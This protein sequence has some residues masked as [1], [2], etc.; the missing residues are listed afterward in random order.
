MGH[1]GSCSPGLRVVDK[2]VGAA[3]WVIQTLACGHLPLERARPVRG[4]WGKTTPA[5]TSVKALMA[6]EWE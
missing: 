2:V 4:A 6:G 3:W 5:R 1:H